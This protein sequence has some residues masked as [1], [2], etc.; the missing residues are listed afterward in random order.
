MT[1]L[2]WQLREAGL[3]ERA[4]STVQVIVTQMDPVLL[5]LYLEL[6]S[7]LRLAGINSE[8]QLAPAKLA[9]QLKY[10]S[11]AGIRFALIAGSNEVDKGVVMVK[12]LSKGEQFEVA[13]AELIKTLRV[14]IEQAQA[15][16]AMARA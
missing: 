2:F 14:E 5:P 8:L 6:A 4:Q 13:R 11:K 1:R 15:L 3:I 12:D 16:A 9:R 10:A 7:S